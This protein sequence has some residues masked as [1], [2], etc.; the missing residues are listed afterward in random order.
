M[1]YSDIFCAV[2]MEIY[3][4]TTPLCDLIIITLELCHVQLIRNC[5]QIY[6]IFCSCF[7]YNLHKPIKF[8]HFSEMIRC[9][10]FQTPLVFTQLLPN[11]IWPS[12]QRNEASSDTIFE[13][14]PMVRSLYTSTDMKEDISIT[15]DS[16]DGFQH[17]S[18]LL[19]SNHT[20]NAT[21]VYSSEVWL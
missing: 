20:Q 17:I 2:L 1:E 7:S 14:N 18:C 16:M 11:Q 5:S 6:I 15:F 4:D 12:K 8:Y 21:Y 19:L 3:S 9:I 13:A 10:L